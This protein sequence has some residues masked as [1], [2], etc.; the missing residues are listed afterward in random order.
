LALSINGGDPSGIETYVLQ[1][2]QELTSGPEKIRPA[3][4]PQVGPG[5]QALVDYLFYPARPAIPGA[6][7]RKLKSPIDDLPASIGSL[8]LIPDIVSH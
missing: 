6:I 3:G 8:N 2:E 5:D 7:P 1:A 4:D